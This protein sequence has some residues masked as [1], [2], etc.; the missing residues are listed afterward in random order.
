MFPGCRAPP[1]PG[2]RHGIPPTRLEPSSASSCAREKNSRQR[3]LKSEMG[4]MGYKF[5]RKPSFWKILYHPDALS[6]QYPTRFSHAVRSSLF[7]SLRRSVRVARLSP[8][9]PPPALRKTPPSS[10]G[11]LVRARPSE[12]ATATSRSVG[13]EQP[14]PPS[15]ALARSHPGLGLPWA[16][17]EPQGAPGAPLRPPWGPRGSQNNPQTTTEQLQ[18]N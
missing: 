1:R 11:P 10:P 6:L 4:R 13:L 9:K 7:F 5:Q 14:P 18:N 17:W 8:Q 16:S 12:G 3:F 15:L 2:R